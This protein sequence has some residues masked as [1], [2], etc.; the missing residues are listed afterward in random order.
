M[1]ERVYRYFDYA[2]ATPLSEAALAVMQPYWTD[3]FYNP[4]ALYLAAKDVRH[5]LEAARATVS[6]QIGARP[7]EIVF[8]AGGSEAN[9]L[10]IHG[11][12]RRYPHNTVVISSVEHESVMAPAG[13]YN[14][15]HV[16]VSEKGIID[17]AS[18][19]SLVDDSTVLLSV[20][21]VNNEVGAIQP[22]R[23]ITAW[24]AAVR[25]DRKSREIDTP[26]FVHTD[27]CQAGNYLDMHVNRLGVDLMTVNGGKLYGPKQSGALYVRAGIVLQPIVDGGGQEWG[28]RS[29][30][31]NVA[32]AAGFA[33]A[34]QAA[35][36]TAH[37]EAH[38]LSDLRDF[39]IA[40][41]ERQVSGLIINGPSGS[42]R[43][44]NNIHI[45]IPGYDNERLLMELDE[46]GFQ[47]ATG[48]ACSASNDEPSHVLKAMGCSDQDAQSSLRITTGRFTTEQ[49]LIDLVETITNLVAKR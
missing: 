46:R 16:P 40:M 19:K 15:T 38:R 11:V 47:V 12:M 41:L 24:V 34:L 33:A 48:S 26:L 21:Y 14:C 36:E 30:T 42:K 31:E 4:S 44:A 2:A 29:G 37:T 20:M 22:V 1:N 18:L 25:R 9:N 43:L 39:A 27:A 13:H 23:E 10:A 3:K 32:L 45:T 6:Q 17:L 49:D 35:R 28:L 8:T 5:E 7:S